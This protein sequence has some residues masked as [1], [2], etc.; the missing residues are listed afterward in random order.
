MKAENG[1]DNATNGTGSAS[2]A[3]ATQMGTYNIGTEQDGEGVMAVID[4]GSTLD[5]EIS[6]ALVVTE[7]VQVYET[8][9]LDENEA[10]FRQVI[11]QKKRMKA[12][13]LQKMKRE[14]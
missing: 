5:G 11:L 10:R 9:S 3:T 8:P 4:Q 1:A 14:M 6:R 2:G 12:E 13:K 7:P